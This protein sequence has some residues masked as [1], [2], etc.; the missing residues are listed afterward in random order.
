MIESVSRVAK[1][2]VLL[3]LA[4]FMLP[5]LQSY[6]NFRLKLRLVLRNSINSLF[7]CNHFD[8]FDDLFVLLDSFDVTMT[9]MF[10]LPFPCCSF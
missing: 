3:L 1:Q 4:F 6:L 2:K 9:E 8:A 10:L 7:L 5:F